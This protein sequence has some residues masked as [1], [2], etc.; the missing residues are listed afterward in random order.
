MNYHCTDTGNIGNLKRTADSIDQKGRT[1]TLALIVTV[2]SK[3]GQEHYRDRMT[4]NTFDKAFRSAVVNDVADNKRMES[5]N[6]SAACCYI[7]MGDIGTLS[8]Q[9]VETDKTV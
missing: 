9:S 3:A 5:D 4:R 1:E 8:R 7:G 2:N 6:F